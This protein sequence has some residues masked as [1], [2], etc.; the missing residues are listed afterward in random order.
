MRN[1]EHICILKA[2]ENVILLN[3]IRFAEEIRPAS[4]LDI[5]KTKA[6]PAEMKMAIHLID[7]LTK[8]FDIKNIKMNIVENY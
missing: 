7:E 4:E 1:R 6:K 8:P 3:R 5:P 2:D